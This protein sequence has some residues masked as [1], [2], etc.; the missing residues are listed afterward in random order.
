MNHVLNSFLPLFHRKQM[1][2]CRCYYF[3]SSVQTRPGA[4]RDPFRNSKLVRP[5]QLWSS[6]TPPSFRFVIIACFRSSLLPIPIGQFLHSCLYHSV[7][8]MM[9]ISPGWL[10]ITSFIIWPL[11][12]TPANGL[13]NFIC[14]TFNLFLSFIALLMFRIHAIMCVYLWFY[15]VQVA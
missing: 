8:S 2:A 7:S 1:F 4:R 9:M 5:F 11:L 10:L 14:W 13:R 15:E 6:N 12:Q 3:S